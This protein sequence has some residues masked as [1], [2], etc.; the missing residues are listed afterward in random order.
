[1]PEGITTGPDG[2]LWFANDA[3]DSIGRITTAGAVT[4]F[5]GNGIDNPEGITSGPDGAL[6]FTNYGDNSIGRITTAGVVTNYTGTGIDEPNGITTGPDGALWFTNDGNN[7]IGR[8]TTAGVVTNYTGI[9]IDNP[10]SITTGSD[11]ALWFINDNAKNT[12]SIG[13]ITTAGVVTNY[14]GTG[15]NTPRD[16]TSGPDGA[17]WFT[18]SFGPSCCHGQRVDREDHH[19]GK[20]FHLHGARHQ[21][22]GQ[23]S[24]PAPTGRCGS[25]MTETTRARLG[26]SPRPGPSPFSRATHVGPGSITT[27]PDGALWFDNSN[28][29]V[30]RITTSGIVSNYSGPG[31]GAEGITRA[32]TGHCGSPISANDIG[33]VTVPAPA[34]ASFSPNSGCG[35]HKRHR[36]RER[37][38]GCKFRDDRRGRCNDHQG[39]RHQDQVHR[40]VWSQQRQDQGHDTERHRCQRHEIHG[41]ELERGRRAYA[42]DDSGGRQSP[43]IVMLRV[44]PDESCGSAWGY[45]SSSGR[46]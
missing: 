23:G 20:G 13:R 46:S 35:G 30:G 17:L 26:G 12:F 1:M 11:G 4:N 39:H 19:V 2:A 41:P 31:V 43:F 16:I 28:N 27:G 15:I 7:S 8:I 3:G 45:R 38:G 6:W 40:P 29:E 14:T 22:P 44:I 36:H 25:P 9:G 24:P 33:R 34:L 32:P 18:N 5:T 21:T 42:P 10:Q 37:V